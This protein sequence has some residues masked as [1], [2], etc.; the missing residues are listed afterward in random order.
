MVHL[1]KVNL[2]FSKWGE[3]FVDIVGCVYKDTENGKCKL[4]IEYNKEKKELKL[5][6]EDNEIKFNTLERKAPDLETP[7]KDMEIGGFGIFIAKESMD[8]IEYKY[9]DKKI[10]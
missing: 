10:F 8:N 5:T 3:L 1:Y 2:F 4:K 7:L 9:E 6:F